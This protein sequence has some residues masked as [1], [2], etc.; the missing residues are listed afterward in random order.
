MSSTKMRFGL[1]GAGGIAQTYAQALAQSA[2]GASSSPS[3]TCGREA[4]AGAGRAARLPARSTSHDDLL[5][6]T[7]AAT[8]RS[9]ARRRSRIREI[10]CALLDR[11]R[12]RA[13]REAAGDRPRRGPRDGRRRRAVASRV[14]TMA[15]KFRYVDDVVEAKSIVASGMIGEVVLFENAF[16]VAR[17][18]DAAAGT[19]TRRSAAAAC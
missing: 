19:P 11:G 5:D 17:R 7:R 10:C 12:A 13:V 4:A 2:D 14:L 3:P 8:R 15:S 1:V 16:T 9:S 6:G 18:H